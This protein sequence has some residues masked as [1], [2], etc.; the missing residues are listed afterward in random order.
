MNALQESAQ[1]QRQ[2]QRGQHYRG[3][4]MIPR[5]F[6]NPAFSPA[7][8]THVRQTAVARRDVRR[9]TTSEWTTGERERERER[10]RRGGGVG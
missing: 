2:V 7:V 1:V 3:Q 5:E 9:T 10:S 8:R 4:E 6:P